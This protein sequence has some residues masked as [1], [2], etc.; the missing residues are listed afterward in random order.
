MSIQDT[1]RDIASGQGLLACDEAADRI[2]QLEKEL[3]EARKDAARYRHLRNRDID[4]IDNVSCD[5]WLIGP[6]DGERLDAA[7][8]AA[9][10]TP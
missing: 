8:D 7:I 2:D 1:L 4:V 5:F 9:M 10:E 6:N 3:I